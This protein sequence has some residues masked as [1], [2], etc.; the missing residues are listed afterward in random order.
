MRCKKKQKIPVLDIPGLA[1]FQFLHGNPPTLEL[2]G[3]RV[4]GMFSVDTHFFEL[5]ARFNSNED[6]PV[7]DYLKAQREL[8]AKMMAL[9]LEGGQK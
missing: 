9:K 6:V 3:T 7:L 5:S 8:R 4:T 2:N 1:S